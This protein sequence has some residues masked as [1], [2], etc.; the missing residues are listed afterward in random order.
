MTDLPRRAQEIFEAAIDLAADERIAYVEQA[1]SSDAQLLDHVMTLLMYVD[2]GDETELSPTLT[3]PDEMVGTTIDQY[4]IRSFIGEGGFGAVYLAEQSEP[5]RRRVAIK[6]IKLGMDTKA[7]VARFQAERQ[8]LALMDHPGIARIFDG[9]TTP[10]GRPYFV[11]EYV[12]GVPVTEF[13]DTERVSLKERIT[14]FRDICDAIQHAHTKGVIHRD[15]KPSNILVAYQDGEPSIKVIDFGIAKALDQQMSEHTLFT[16]TGQLMGTPEY[17]SPEQAEMSALNVDTRSDVY[18]LGVLLYELLSGRLPFDTT[19]L[20]AAGLGEIQRIIREEEPPKPST[21]CSSMITKSIDESKLIAKAR[22]VDPAS[23]PRRLRGDLD[24]IVMKCLEKERTRR[25]DTASALSV[26][27]GRH[28]NNEP[29]EASPPSAIYRFKKFARRKSGLLFALSAVFLVLVCGFVVS[30]VFAIEA[31]YQREAAL[32]ALD[33]ADQQRKNAESLNTRLIGLRDYAKFGLMWAIRPE[34][35]EH[36]DTRAVK[37]FLDDA[38]T[39]LS[40]PLFQT[41]DLSEADLLN[42]VGGLYREFGFPGD[43][44][45][46]IARSVQIREDILGAEHLETLWAEAIYGQLIYRLGRDYEALMYFG[47]V[48]N[49]YPELLT[50]DSSEVHDLIIFTFM[51]A[52]EVAPDF[53]DANI[54]LALD[55]I[56]SYH[57][58]HHP[59]TAELLGS[60]SNRFHQLEEYEEAYAFRLRATDAWIN[61]YGSDSRDYLMS[62]GILSSLA[63]KMGEH[64]VG[65]M[66]GLE[67][68]DS[69]NRPITPHYLRTIG[70]LCVNLYKLERYSEA[71]KHWVDQVNGYIDLMGSDDPETISAAGLLI[72]LYEVTG[73]P[74]EAQKYRDMLPETEE[75]QDASDSTQEQSEK[76]PVPTGG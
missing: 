31:S 65:V 51:A 66:H 75:D 21:R 54:D 8:A 11:M 64:E 14:L 33:T 55:I 56:V 15:L 38:A 19:K 62:M 6:V 4:S 22:H 30:I 50:R 72:K 13:C 42:L 47:R 23:L 74:E 18:S 45:P 28:L 44:E 25:Y 52:T 57:G 29:V 35:V 10:Q 49:R 34:D 9:G 36:M 7:V 63:Y 5:V 16:N 43:A 76:E 53:F 41:N 69:W 24:W 27:L 67:F 61:T 32:R 48:I 60:K 26:D 68:I 46:L 12:K 39:A 73:K 17:M 70:W 71:E 3:A 40:S 20:R 58:E 1:C 2:V 59:Y 37:L